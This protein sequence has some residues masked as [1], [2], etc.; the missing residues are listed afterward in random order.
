VEQRDDGALNILVLDQAMDPAAPRISRRSFCKVAA[1]VGLAAAGS[2]FLAACARLGG[3]QTAPQELA[4]ELNFYNWSDYIAEDTLPNFQKRFGV[5]VNYDNYSSNDTLFAKL[6]AGAT[7]YD[8]VVPTDYLVRRMLRLNMLEELNLANIPNRKNLD[9]RFQNP[10]YDPGNK[11]SIPWQWGTTGIG[12]NTKR[13]AESVESWAMLWNA[14]YRGKISMLAEMRDA[15]GATLI[16]LGFSGSSTKA[17]ELEAAKAK[18]LEQ[19]PLLKHYTSDTYIDELA[20]NDVWLAQG[21][22][23]DVFQAQGENKDVDYVIPKEGSFI[24]VDNMVIP[25]GAPHKYTA[26]VFMNYVLEAEVGAAIS[27]FVRY[28]S[29]NKAAEAHLDKDLLADTRV[30]PSSQVMD[31]LQFYG[32]LGPAE[33]LW[34]KI[35]QEVRAG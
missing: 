28:A 14:K 11:H 22:S 17:E 13:V 8:I 35:W 1:G 10:P 27:N 16:L 32:D 15:L 7:N 23:G 4:K 30:Y 3:R 6:R 2:S 20:S 33:T 5:K 9:A 19:K 24:W 12:Y 18:M 34:N 21:W 31:A 29:P 26:E 25:K